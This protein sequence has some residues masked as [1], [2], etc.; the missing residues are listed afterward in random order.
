MQR[1]LARLRFRREQLENSRKGH[2]E[3]KAL[4]T[5][6]FMSRL[7]PRPT[8]ILSSSGW[9]RSSSALGGL[10]VPQKADPCLRQAGLFASRA[11][12]ATAGRGGKRAGRLSGGQ[13]VYFWGWATG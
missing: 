11:R 4:R 1:G 8:K 10:A 9:A 12:P 3:M 2:R 7:K 13:V 5:V 6:F